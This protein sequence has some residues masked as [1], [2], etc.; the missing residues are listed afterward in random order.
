MVRYN[1]INVKFSNLQVSKLK[2]AVKNNEGTTLRISAKMFNS[3]NLPHES[4]LTTRQITKLRNNIENDMSSGI[5][6]NKA[7][8]KKLIMSLGNLGSSLRKFSSPLIKIA[9]PLVTKILPTLGLSAAISGI[10]G[11]IKNKNKKYMVE[12]QQL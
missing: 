12:E 10:D 8:I 11:A 7:Q 4:F 1:K 5:K 6:L 2:I 3:D 9:K